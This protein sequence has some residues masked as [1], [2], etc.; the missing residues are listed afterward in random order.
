MVEVCVN[1]PERLIVDVGN[2]VIDVYLEGYGLI[3]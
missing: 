3:L 1:H 2:R